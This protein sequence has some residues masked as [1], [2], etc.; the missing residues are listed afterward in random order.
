MNINTSTVFLYVRIKNLT[1]E[2][3]WKPIMR[4]G[5]YPKGKAPN[6]ARAVEA[7]N[8]T[9]VSWLIAPEFAPLCKNWPLGSQYDL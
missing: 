5:K 4:R 7:G 9:G 2:R 8:R 3:K 1:F 6:L